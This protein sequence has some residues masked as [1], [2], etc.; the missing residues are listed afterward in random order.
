MC[1]SGHAFYSIFCRLFYATFCTSYRYVAV[2]IADC[3]RYDQ[4]VFAFLAFYHLLIPLV[5]SSASAIEP[6]EVGLE[7]LI[8]AK[9]GKVMC[10]EALCFFEFWVL[11][12]AAWQIP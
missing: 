1:E 3:W 2:V 8:Y 11:D 5:A 6:K 9:I 7:S 12:K 4:H 10:D